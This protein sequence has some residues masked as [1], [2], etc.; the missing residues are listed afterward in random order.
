MACEKCRS[1]KIKC[2]GTRPQC[3]NCALR[4]TP[5]VYDGERQK[6]RKLS[7]PEIETRLCRVENLFRNIQEPAIS[8]FNFDEPITFSNTN[9]PS[10]QTLLDSA[11]TNEGQP[12]KERSLGTEV[13]NDSSPESQSSRTGCDKE[14]FDCAITEPIVGGMSR[15][16]PSRLTPAST[17][18]IDDILAYGV[19]EGPTD[20]NIAVWIRTSD[21]DEYTGPSSGVSIL[22]DLGLKWI[23]DNVGGSE[24]FCSTFADLR[25]SILNHLRI[26]KCM[27]SDPW[28]YTGNERERKPLPPEHDMRRYIEAYFGDVQ[29]IMPILD[30][31]TFER[32]LSA[33]M[34]NSST[35]STSWLALLNAVIASGCRAAL[36]SETAEAFQQSGN[37]A[38]GYFQNALNYEIE[39]IHKATDLTAVQAFTVMTVY[40]QGMSSP[41]RLEYTLCSI[42]VRQGQG[43]GLQR[44]TPSEW[45]LRPAE[46]QERNRLFWVIYFLDK[47]ISLRCGRPSIIDDGEISCPFPKVCQDVQRPHVDNHDRPVQGYNVSEPVF[48]ILL[49]LTGFAMICGRIA[50]RLYSATAL[51]QPFIR[52][53]DTALELSAQLEHWRRNIPAAFRPWQPFR[54]SRLPANVSKTQGLAL[55]FGYNY[56]VCAIH[57]RFTSFFVPGGADLEDVH[58]RLAELR[59]GVSHIEAAR[60]MILLTKHLDI[61]SYVSGW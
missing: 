7:G 3:K 4:S 28:R 43:I 45:N 55:A 52:L 34:E 11:W 57:R 54:P 15:Q 39:L 59:Q 27:P 38:W 50:K 56:A 41:Q 46:M 22:S 60:S 6:R 14:S 19:P 44:S 20:S 53:I 17:S 18:P 49:S 13:E 23:R 31:Q 61:E 47:T 8:E 51:S 40:A 10:F 21:G 30:R 36:S 24:L 37:E 42:A 16:G 25:N 33:F 12:P 2:D 29:C 26:P 1:R 9:S 5:C 58:A 48:D 35:S 32:Q